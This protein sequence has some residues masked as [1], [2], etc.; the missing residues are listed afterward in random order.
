MLAA[1]TAMKIKDH[2]GAAAAYDRALK[3]S[4]KSPFL[5]GKELA[6]LFSDAGQAN[7]FSGKP[8]K[9]EAY[10]KRA[11][12]DLEAEANIHYN[13]A[14]ALSLQGKLRESARAFRDCLRVARKPDQS[15]KYRNL[16][17]TDAQ[18]RRLRKTS[19]YAR[20]MKSE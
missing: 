13:P 20:L 12:K 7:L 18:L 14:C 6:W 9:A 11:L 4:A 8:R 3:V 16:S 10:F 19:L 5:K 15:N 1:A 17:K 2:R